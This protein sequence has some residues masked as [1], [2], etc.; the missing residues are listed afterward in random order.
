MT[1]IA[2]VLAYV[3]ALV[4]VSNM[5]KARGRDTFSYVIFAIMF[6][7]VIIG[8]LLGVLGERP[9]AKPL[10]ADDLTRLVRINAGLF[11]AIVALG[12]FAFTWS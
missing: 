10:S 3:L 2:F 4:I 7:P 1:A 11:V 8:F 9:N 5:A 12:V 6:T